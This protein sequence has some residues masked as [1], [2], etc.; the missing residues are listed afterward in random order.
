MIDALVGMQANFAQYVNVQG[1]SLLA[2]TQGTHEIEN[3]H[4]VVQYLLCCMF[5]CM[6]VSM[7]NLFN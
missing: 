7:Y 6:Y 5:V 3:I 2:L 4:H 1:G